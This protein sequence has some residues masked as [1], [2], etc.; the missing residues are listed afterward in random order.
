M[1]ENNV[2]KYEKNPDCWEANQTWKRFFEK[3]SSK[4][5]NLENIVQTEKN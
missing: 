1:N 3:D 2:I 5:K 4:P